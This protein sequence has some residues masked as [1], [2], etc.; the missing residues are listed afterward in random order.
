MVFLSYQSF[1]N[2]VVYYSFPKVC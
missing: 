2:F 1:S